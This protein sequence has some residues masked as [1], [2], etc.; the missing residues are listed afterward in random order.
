MGSPGPSVWAAL[1]SPA[2]LCLSSLQASVLCEGVP[3]SLYTV[4]PRL[5]S[6]LGFPERAGRPPPPPS[7][8]Y[9]STFPEA[10]GTP[11]QARTCQVPTQPDHPTAVWNPGVLVAGARPQLRGVTSALT[12]DLRGVCDVHTWSLTSSPSGSLPLRSHPQPLAASDKGCSDVELV[13]CSHLRPLPLTRMAR[14]PHGI[15]DPCGISGGACSGH[16]TSVLETL[17]SEGAVGQ[18]T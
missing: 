6:C 14:S 8:A 12:T 11:A 5:P 9:K 7:F 17:G 1:V 16:H 4:A 10:T 3:W 2:S 13:F 15:S 18:E